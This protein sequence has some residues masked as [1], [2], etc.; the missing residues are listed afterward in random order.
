MKQRIC[1]DNDEGE[2]KHGTFIVPEVSSTSRC[3][4]VHLHCAN[5][6]NYNI[7]KFIRLARGHFLKHFVLETFLQESLS[8]LTNM[9]PPFVVDFLALVVKK[10]WKKNMVLEPLS[11]IQLWF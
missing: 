9:N 5:A 7:V 1:L 3:S 10:T 6:V 4:H 2:R 11:L 8:S